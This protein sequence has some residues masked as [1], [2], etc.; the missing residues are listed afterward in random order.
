MICIKKGKIKN[1]TVGKF[2]KVTRTNNGVHYGSDISY[3]NVWVINDAGIEKHYSGK[4]F[5]DVTQWRDIQLNTILD[6]N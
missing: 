6:E 5:V 3:S 1:L 2:Y 4:R